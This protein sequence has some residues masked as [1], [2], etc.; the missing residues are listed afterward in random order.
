VG[1]RALTYTRTE[2]FETLAAEQD[3]AT[4]MQFTNVIGLPLTKSNML[5]DVLV[6]SDVY[7][8]SHTQRNFFGARAEGESRVNASSRDWQHLVLSGKAA[9]FFR[10]RPRWVSEVALEGAGAWR[11]DV[12][13]QLALGDNPGGLSAYAHSRDVG[14]QRLMARVEQRFDLARY[15]MTRGAFGAAAFLDAGRL[16]AGDV[17]FGRNTPI[18]LSTGVALLGAWPA[19]SQRTLRAEL[20]IPWTRAEGARPEVRFLIREPIAGFFQDPPRIRWARLS[21]GP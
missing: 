21:T 3:I 5:G 8:G 6:V 17:P 7:M 2:G 16:W 4:G 10:P 11:S 19:R 12:P 13:F 1:I 9:W 18:R 15:Q 20:A 14:A